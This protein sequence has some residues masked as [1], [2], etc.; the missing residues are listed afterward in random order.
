MSLSGH[1]QERR[2][3]LCY[4]DGLTSRTIGINP[5]SHD[6]VN[7]TVLLFIGLLL[8]LCFISMVHSFFLLSL[9]LDKWH[10]GDEVWV[11]QTVITFQAQ[12]PW[13]DNF[14]V[15]TNRIGLPLI[16]SVTNLQTPRRCNTGCSILPLLDL[17]WL[18][19]ILAKEVQWHLA[20]LPTMQD[21]VTS[22]YTTLLPRALERFWIM[23]GFPRPS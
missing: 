7:T 16:F 22:L 12:A 1:L 13:D 8:F 9:S 10:T 6:W 21:L 3:S 19:C 15:L 4:G 11:C 14:W 23:S 18:L 17:I 2:P 5:T 20:G